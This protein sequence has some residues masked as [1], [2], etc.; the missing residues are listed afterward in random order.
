MSRTKVKLAE[1][2]E[3]E[4]TVSKSKARRYIFLFFLPFF[5]PIH[6]HL[7]FFISL[8]PVQNSPCVYHI[9]VQYIQLQLDNLWGLVT[10]L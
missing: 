1:R 8:S 4:A 7:L 2:A 9:V 6:L 10:V 5:L 3:G